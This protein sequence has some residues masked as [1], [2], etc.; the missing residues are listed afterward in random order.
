M[1]MNTNSRNFEHCVIIEICVIIF[2]CCS[3]AFNSLAIVRFR[4]RISVAIS[5]SIDSIQWSA[6][7]FSYIIPEFF[8]EF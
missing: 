6:I 7:S 3:V 1:N 4:T 2:L 5:V 8:G